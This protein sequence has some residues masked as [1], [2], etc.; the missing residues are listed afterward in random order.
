[1]I[2][3]RRYLQFNDL[4]L[5]TY[6][7]LSDTEHTAEFKGETSEYS[8]GHGSYDP[9]KRDYLFVREQEVSLSVTLM[10]LKLPCDFRPFYKKFAIRELTRP[11][12]LWAVVN[13]ELLWAY[14]R[15]TSIS[16]GVDTRKDE[17]RLEIDLLLP[18]GIWHKADKTKTFL[19]PYDVCDFMDCLGFKEINP[20]EHIPLDGD[21]CTMCTEN[22]P[23]HEDLEDCCC[24]CDNLTKD[25]ALCYHKD[26]LQGV[27]A[28]CVPTFQ[29]FYDCKK[30]HE[31][32]ADQYLGEKICAKTPCDNIIAGRF[33][34]DT[35][36][37][38]TSMELVID[39]AVHN[40]QITING[41]RNIIK[42]DYDRL[43]IKSNGD[44]YSETKNKCCRKL[45]DPSV[46][47]IP[48]RNDDYGWEIK[49]GENSLI[50]DRGSCCGMACAYIQMDNLTI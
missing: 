49:Q 42:G 14:A 27:Y 28:S 17:Y 8:F 34:S 48:T 45:L 9:Y 7:M 18:E 11:G 12:K 50:I 5:D 13:N 41:N 19:A 3:Y 23:R 32:F 44:V 2:Y 36:I 47:V 30:A 20:C 16:E 35:E 37:P 33:Y 26:E 29:V 15:A 4:V 24:C 25:M 40:A 10:M 38:S 22:P 1:M 43:F 31:F 21:C 6:D 46:W 39:G